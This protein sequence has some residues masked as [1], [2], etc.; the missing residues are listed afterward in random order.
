MLGLN[1]SLLPFHPRLLRSHQL[2]LLFR[3]R[4]VVF[5]VPL[6][7]AAVVSFRALASVTSYLF[8]SSHFNRVSPP[9]L[10]PPQGHLDI[11]SRDESNSALHHHEQPVHHLED[12]HLYQDLSEHGEPVEAINISEDLKKIHNSDNQYH[13]ENE[14]NF[15]ENGRDDVGPVRDLSFRSNEVSTGQEES[16]L[17]V[18]D[19]IARSNSNATS[20]DQIP[21]ISVVVLF[22]AEYPTLNH[23]L[24]TW[25]ANGLLD[26][27]SEFLF[28]L[29][30]MKSRDEFD[31]KMPRLKHP[32]WH[33]LVR[34]IPSAEN[35]PLGIA[36]N[37]MVRLARHEL[38]LLLEKDWALIEPPEE[39]RLQ[40]FTSAQLLQSGT[41]HLVRYRHR[42][43]PGAPLHA[44]I[45][46]ENREPQMLSAQSNLYCFMHHWVSNLSV[47]YSEY[48][49]P[50]KGNFNLS[51]TVWCAKARYCQWTNNPGLFYR[52]WFLEKLGGP[53]V[54]NYKASADK[55]N[56][57]SGM[58]DFEFFMNWKL[59]VW[60]DRDY[61]VA[62]PKGLFEHEEV[63]EQNLMNTVWYAWSRL[64]TDV[65]EKSSAYFEVERDQCKLEKTHASGLSYRE[66]FPLDFVHLYHY[67]R[68]MQRTTAEA[69][70]ELSEEVAR[71]R[72]QLEEGHGNWRN[73]VTDLTNMWYKVVLFEYPV[74]PPAMRLA[75]LSALF[76]PEEKDVAD[77]ADIQALGGNMDKLKQYDLVI[78]T[79]D[80]SRESLKDALI[81]RSGWTEKDIEGVTWITGSAKDLMSRVLTVEVTMRVEKLRTDAKWTD[82]VKR[83]T[84]GTTPSL[85]EV[86]L[87]LA[88]PLLLRTVEQ[89]SAR[90]GEDDSQMSP[91]LRNA[92]HFVWFDATS[93]C[94]E[95]NG[96]A[97][98]G[99]KMSDKNDHVFRG[100]MLLNTM[101]SGRRVESEEELEAM[102]GASGFDM[103]VFL[104]ETET[105]DLRQGLNLVDGRTIGGSRLAL[106]LMSGYYDVVLRD[107]L[108]RGHL[109]TAREPLSIAVKNVLYN[110][111]FVDAWR[112][113][114]GGGCGEASTFKVGMANADSEDGCRIYDWAGKCSISGT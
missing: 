109:G 6:L 85:T 14:T 47:S 99:S 46:H 19:K 44:R 84:G 81:Q 1:Q 91:K 30:G 73:G 20:S 5:L 21:P 112:S 34:V 65:E 93:R 24:E 68:A 56:S 23:T 27:I 64:S 90:A 8:S 100:N 33:G 39:T 50:C 69:V 89:L 58:L 43:R 97:F 88:K 72:R 104:K 36:I 75:F 62:L 76:P 7:V 25:E 52:K 59:E 55:G 54:E 3:Q 63:G 31:E 87:E 37:E 17:I 26:V 12:S 22:H 98:S 29:N 42:H 96:A 16:N 105:S 66:K 49:S 2:R 15:D 108:R 78:F 86:L 57:Q 10:H 83:R 102:L 70:E 13:G 67:N 106:T 77:V 95:K 110:F 53:F 11:S 107:M 38:V 41:A 48:F 28:F 4:R 45:M 82:T 114:N 113:C 101:V 35:L 32:R 61:V 74:E 60:N 92:T 18:T 40:L 71:L 80:K 94:L 111:K 79:N 9:T 51:E 103:E